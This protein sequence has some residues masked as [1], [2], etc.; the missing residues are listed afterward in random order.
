MSEKRI[1]VTGAGGFIGTHLVARLCLEYK[2]AVIVLADIKPTHDW[3][4]DGNWIPE[5]NDNGNT[6]TYVVGDLRDDAVAK[7]L[8]CQRFDETWHLAC[9]HGGIGYLKSREYECGLDI[10]INANVL[11]Y[12]IESGSGT[13][14][15]AS[16]ACVYNEDLQQD[17][18]N[19]VY[20][21]ESDVY[22]ANPDSVYGWVK[23]L[24]EQ[25]II[26]AQKE[27]GLDA[28]IA[29]IHGCYGTHGAFD[30]IKEKA[31]NA[32]MRKA[33]SS[34]TTLDVWGGLDTVRSFMYVSDC[35]EAFMRLMRSDY[36]KP[37]NIGSDMTVT[38]GEV[39]NIANEIAHSTGNLLPIN[40]VSGE[41][42]VACRSC[43]CTL[44]EEVLDFKPSIHVRDGLAKVYNWQKL[45]F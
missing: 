24:T 23:L 19:T 40:V 25:M 20:L 7:E 45:M 27:R 8:F 42:G 22:P 1:L 41:R 9:D 39:A 44:M 3:N 2:N 6:L 35:V 5:F 37:I 32:L 26:A 15:F 29:R 14:F 11:K 31:P 17:T 28:R 38:I 30:N 13:F 18:S 12:H 43:D 10:S 34:K 16:S 33:S 36:D 21:K 4:V